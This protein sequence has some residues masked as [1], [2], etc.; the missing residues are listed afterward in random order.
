MLLGHLYTFSELSVQILCLFNWLVFL[1]LFVRVV[2]LLWI[3]D[4]YQ[5]HDMQTSSPILRVLFIFLIVLFESQTFLILVKSKLPIYFFA[6]VFHLCFLLRV[7]I[8]SALKF[9]SLIHFKLI[10]VWGKNQTFFFYML[11]PNCPTTICWKD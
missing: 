3:L 2:C 5:I 11:I 7:F 1:L 6:C 10:F 8:V 4:P 9:N